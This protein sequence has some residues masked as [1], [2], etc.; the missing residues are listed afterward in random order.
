MHR[1]GWEVD[2]LQRLSDECQWVMRQLARLKCTRADQSMPRQLTDLR[3]RMV[4][5]VKG[6]MPFRRTPATHIAV[7]MISDERRSKKPYAVPIQ[8]VPYRGMNE[9]LGRRLVKTI[10]AEMNR[11]SMRVSGKWHTCKARPNIR[12]AEEVTW[13]QT[14]IHLHER[15]VPKKSQH[16]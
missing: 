5:F 15:K 12:H 10:V 8:C 4:E 2:E 11:R 1:L 16:L 13:V 9:V 7:Y 6:I 3:Q 14:A